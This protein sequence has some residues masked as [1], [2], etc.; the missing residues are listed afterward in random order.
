MAYQEWLAGLKPGDKVMEYYSGGFASVYREGVVSRVTKTQILAIFRED[1]PEERY[2]RTTGRMLSAR[3]FSKH[4]LVE[5][6]QEVLDEIE[7][8]RLRHKARS[9][10]EKVTIPLTISELTALIEALKPYVQ[11]S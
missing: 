1:G 10:L 7:T 4:S 2:N 11:E 9:I 3:G 6:T 8:D 5:P